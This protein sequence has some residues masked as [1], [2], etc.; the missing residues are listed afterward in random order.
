MDKNNFFYD[1]L[2]HN[3]SVQ[4]FFKNAD[5]MIS[6][7]N[8]SNNISGA[9]YC[10][11]CG[12]NSI[13]V[14]KVNP[15]YLTTFMETSQKYTQITSMKKNIIVDWTKS[16]LEQFN[17]FI[18]DEV[19]Y[20]RS[21]HHKIILNILRLVSL[22]ILTNTLFYTFHVGNIS[23]FLLRLFLSVGLFYYL[24][25]L[26][27]FAHKLTGNAYFRNS[28]LLFYLS[29]IEFT[30]AFFA[31]P[32]FSGWFLLLSILFL[33]LVIVPTEKVLSIFDKLSVLTREADSNVMSK[34]TQTELL[35]NQSLSHN[36]V[37]SSKSNTAVAVA[38]VLGVIIVFTGI[39][40]GGIFY[41]TNSA[42]GSYS[43]GIKGTAEVK[44]KILFVNV[45][46]EIVVLGKSQKFKGNVDWVNQTIEIKLPVA[47][48]GIGDRISGTYKKDSQ[49]N[50]MVG[51]DNINPIQ[52]K[53]D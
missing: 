40:L 43:L 48:P 11:K 8:C 30:L 16:K 24:G 1:K 26:V 18:S 35:L 25:L 44:V 38:K 6:C 47:V 3:D 10:S 17:I 14:T 20:T 53:R 51:A 32:L 2:K 52:L 50:L 13:V 37:A 45:D 41:M 22:F 42:D 9:N 28:I 15:N 19:I 33:V 27:I 23:V 29:L 21:K 12:E 4:K 46:G 36:A 34:N 31:Y 7:S 49:G 5:S 39:V